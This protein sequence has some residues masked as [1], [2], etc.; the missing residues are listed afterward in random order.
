[1]VS[2]D[3]FSAADIDP[4]A[5]AETLTVEEWGRLAACASENPVP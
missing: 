2:P 3:A 4:A 5:R 1:L